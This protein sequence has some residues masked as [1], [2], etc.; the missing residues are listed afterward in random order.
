MSSDNEFCDTLKD[1][2]KYEIKLHS[3]LMDICR[4][5]LKKLSIVSVIGILE[6]VKHETIEFEQAAKK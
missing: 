4:D 2:R 1:Y 3:E 5:Y 6:I